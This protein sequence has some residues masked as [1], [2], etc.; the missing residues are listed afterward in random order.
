MLAPVKPPVH[1]IVPP[2]QPDN[3]KVVE[4][5]AHTL[6]LLAVA[7]KFNTVGGLTVIVIWFELGLTQ[8]PVVQ[9]AE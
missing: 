5:P 9:V 8:V 2:E 7:V 6:G 3:V 1:V 4:E